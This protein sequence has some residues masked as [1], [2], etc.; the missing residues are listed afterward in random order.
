M[1][2]GLKKDRSDLKNMPKQLKITVTKLA[3]HGDSQVCAWQLGLTTQRRTRGGI[4]GAASE[5]EMLRGFARAE[6]LHSHLQSSLQGNSVHPM[7]LLLDQTQ[8]YQKDD[9]RLLSF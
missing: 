8:G 1:C 4:C 7:L 2:H 9:K 5:P 3:D 6:W